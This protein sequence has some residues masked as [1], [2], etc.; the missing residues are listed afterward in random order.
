M[1]TEAVLGSAPRRAGGADPLWSQTADIIA[2]R[3]ERGEL[4]AGA[5]LPAERELCARLDIS[6]VTLRK[7]LAH[8]VNRGVLTSSHGRGWFVTAAPAAPEREWPND[9]ESFTATARRKRMRP[10]A[11]VLGHEVVP[12]S[13]D[14]AERLLVPA[15]TP[16]L[17]LERVR[18]LNDVRIAVDLSLV[19][20]ALAPG[21]EQADFATASLFEELRE[22]GVQPDRSVVTIEARAADRAL[23]AELEMAEGTPVLVLD[24]TVYG[25]DQRPALLSTLRYSGERY[26]L[27]TTF[28]P[29]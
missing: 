26:R 7:A 19:P 12:A 3:V 25:R 5:R 17:R 1:G 2:G 16:L 21:L 14:V 10:G 9:L 22:R 29:R 27:R 11:L 15:G 28:Q 13:L 20:V 24:Q 18:T 23:A 6:R 8:L 4:A